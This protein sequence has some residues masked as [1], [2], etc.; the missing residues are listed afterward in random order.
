MEIK[1]ISRFVRTSPQKSRMVRGSVL[2]KEAKDAINI[3]D[4]ISKKPVRFIKKTI[5]SCLANAKQKNPDAQYWYV[6]NILIDEG[7][8]MKR[9]QAATM[10]R[11][12]I[13]RKRFSHITVILDDRM[14]NKK[15][16]V[17][18]KK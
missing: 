9:M 6:K 2:G 10:G 11:G 3:L 13:I 12:V 17:W 5:Q 18:D 4:S 14:I 15:E 8:K 16:E 7:P 1:A